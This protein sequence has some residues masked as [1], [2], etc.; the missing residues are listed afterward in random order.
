M[1]IVGSSTLSYFYPS[2]MLKLGYKTSKSA[3]FM[4]VPIYSVAFVAVVATGYFMDKAPRYRGLVIASWL[5]LATISG[6]VICAVYNYTVR[7]VFLVLMAAGLWAANGL[8]LAYAAATLS[9]MPQETR[10]VA[11]AA[12]N[13]MGNLASIY[14]AYLFPS[15]TSPHFEM[16]FI[17][18]SCMAA[19]GTLVYLAL[20]ILVHRHPMIKTVGDTDT[21]HNPMAESR[22][23]DTEHVADGSMNKSGL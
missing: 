15:S 3:N 21:T 11:L 14:G 9:A 5:S 4:T 22:V 1:V 23:G 6:I 17:V 7:Y 20:H 8:A 10:A 13:C 16:G 12:I 2:L 18:T 19:F